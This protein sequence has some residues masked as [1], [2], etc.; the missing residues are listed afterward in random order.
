L[1]KARKKLGR[2][3]AGNRLYREGIDVTFVTYFA[4]FLLWR[5]MRIRAAC[6]PPG[7]G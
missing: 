2:E 5:R 7:Q 3:T 1:S 4:F 6:D